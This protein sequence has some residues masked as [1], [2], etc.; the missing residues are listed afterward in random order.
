MDMV[1]FFIQLLLPFALFFY[2]FPKTR[3]FQLAAPVSLCLL[4]VS[5]YFMQDSLLALPLPWSYYLFYL[6]PYLAV[7]AASLTMFNMSA[8]N[9]LYFCVF[10]FVLQNFAH[11][12]CRLFMNGVILLAGTDLEAQRFTSFLTYSIFYLTVYSAFY[13]LYLR[14]RRFEADVSISSLPVLALAASFSLVLIVLGIYIRHMQGELLK[15]S[16]IAIVY[17]TY[18]VIL[19][20]FLICLLIGLFRTNKLQSDANELERRLAQ[21]GRYYEMAQANMEIINIKCHDLKH[22]IAALKSMDDSAE[23][24]A[25]IEELQNA[26]MIY[27]NY[28]KTGN[29]ALDCVLTEKGLFCNQKGIRFTYMADGAGLQRMRYMDIYALFGNALDNAIENVVKI[30]D[31]SKRIIS[32]RVFSRG[33]FVNIH[34][35]NYCEEKL[36]FKDGLPV[37]TKA[38]K[39]SHGFGLRSIRYIVQKYGGNIN[40]NITENTFCLS[41]L[42]PLDSEN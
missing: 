25:E 8:F 5:F 32:L 20:V 42:I 17:E 12:L 40:F 26:V 37:T 15:N 29:D 34:M 1:M 30:T 19:D 13:F 38:D 36:T 11:H 14:D 7:V 35:E 27:D 28:A 39:E 18:S 2:R 16:G 41:I 6:I 9:A 24:R 10:S 31:E 3:L 22:Q 33:G 23:R 21:E 4:S